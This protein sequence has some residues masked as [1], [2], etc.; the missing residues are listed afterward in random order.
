MGGLLDSFFGGDDENP[1][2]AAM[3]YL[4]QIPGVA[5]EYFNPF[6]E[7]GKRS[8]DMLEGQYDKFTN[9]PTDYLDQIMS[10][11]RPS[12]GYNFKQNQLLKAAGNSAAAGGFR[13]T[14]NDQQNSAQMVQGLL[15]DDMQQF[16]ANVLGIQGQGIAGHQGF[17]NQGYGAA[18]SLADVLTNN[19]NNQGDLA[20]RGVND[21][22][23]NNRAQREQMMQALTTAATLGMGGGFGGQGFGSAGSSGGVGGGSYGFPSQSQFANG[24]S[25]APVRSGPRG[26]WIG[27]G[28]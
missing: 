25:G 16:L 24:F 11:Y 6:I 23:Q 18:G 9:N 7:R 2:D 20:F 15:G 13:G 12:S 21:Q 1:A 4:N 22:N 28:R 10:R 19:L 8:G 5:K 14:E 3:P 27:G 17:Q 26:S